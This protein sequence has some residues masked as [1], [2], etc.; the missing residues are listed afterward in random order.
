MPSRKIFT[1]VDTVEVQ[2]QEPTTSSATTSSASTELNKL[3][4]DESFD[5]YFSNSD[6]DDSIEKPKIFKTSSCSRRNQ[7]F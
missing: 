3:T 4:A 7:N 2:E 5:L 1:R 6:D